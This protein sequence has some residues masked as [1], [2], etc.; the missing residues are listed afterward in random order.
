MDLRT[1]LEI[2]QQNI[3]LIAQVA[4]IVAASIVL[5]VKLAR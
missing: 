3:I 5:L 1:E 2:N 4:L